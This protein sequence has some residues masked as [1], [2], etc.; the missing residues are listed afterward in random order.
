VHCARDSGNMKTALL[1]PSGF[2]WFGRLPRPTVTTTVGLTLFSSITTDGKLK[3]MDR[4][5]APSWNMQRE[6][7]YPVIGR[8]T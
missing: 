7:P 6:C 2:D 1:W 3:R 5:R 4:R 8:A